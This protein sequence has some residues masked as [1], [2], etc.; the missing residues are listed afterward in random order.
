MKGRGDEEVNVRGLEW[1]CRDFAM[2]PRQITDLATCRLGR[3]TR[4]YFST[5]GRI[6]MRECRVTAS[7]AR[8][9]L[10]VDMI[11]ERSTFALCWEAVEINIKIYTGAIAVGGPSNVTTDGGGVA[12]RE[13]GSIGDAGG[14]VVDDGSRTSESGGKGEG[15]RNDRDGGVHGCLVRVFK[16]WRLHRQV[17]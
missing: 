5:L 13:N 12:I 10:I 4:W 17:R 9:R 15:C 8:H 11:Q 7:V 1:A 2:F 16:L 14:V 6:Q 3:I